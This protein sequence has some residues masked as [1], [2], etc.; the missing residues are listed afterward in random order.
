MIVAPIYSLILCNWTRVG[1]TFA[2]AGRKSSANCRTL[3]NCCHHGTCFWRV[4]TESKISVAG[5]SPKCIRC[6]VFFF[7]VSQGSNSRKHFLLKNQIV[8]I[9]DFCRPYVLYCICVTATVVQKWP[10]ARQSKQDCRDPLSLLLWT[11]RSGFYRLYTC[12]RI[13]F[14]QK[15]SWLFKNI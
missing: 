7:I 1:C 9:L 2:R 15:K 14:F 12:N 13:V 6:T 3:W 11:Q 10:L 5:A 8:G 4:N